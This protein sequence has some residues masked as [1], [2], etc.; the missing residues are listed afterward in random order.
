MPAAYLEWLKDVFEEAQVP[1]GPDTAEYLDKALRNLVNG[2]DQ[3]EEEVFLRLRNRWL[4]HG[5]PGR[6]LLAS[7]LR[8]EVFSRRDSPMR[9]QEGGGYYT[10]DYVATAIPPRRAE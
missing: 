7:F 6:Q 2:Q 3:S 9:P 10:N 1:Y 5:L 4:H 8:D